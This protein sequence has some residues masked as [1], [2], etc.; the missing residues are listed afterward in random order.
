MTHLVKFK[1][2]APA[3][4]FMCGRCQ[5]SP[6]HGGVCSCSGGIYRHRI[7]KLGSRLSVTNNLTPAPPDMTCT[8][9]RGN[10]RPQV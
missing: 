8:L 3:A 4:T 1:T 6:G 2:F 5:S 7:G 10:F 9:W